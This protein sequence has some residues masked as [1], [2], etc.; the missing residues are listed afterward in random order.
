MRLKELREAQGISQSELARRLGIPQQT[1]NHYERGD[2]TLPY[3]VLIQ[4]ANFFC[5][6]TDYLLEFQA[7]NEQKESVTVK[8]KDLG[9]GGQCGWLKELREAMGISRSELA[10]RLGMPRQTYNH[11]ECGDRKLP[12]DVLMQLARFFCVSTDY[13]IGFSDIKTGT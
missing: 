10:R 12:Y 13:L 3:D 2:R 6:T 11:Y 9:G 4:L 1:Y 8:C 7:N 5:V